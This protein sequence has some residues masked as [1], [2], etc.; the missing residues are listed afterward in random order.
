MKVS[1]LNI[2]K[3]SWGLYISTVTTW[4]AI[5]NE[6]SKGNELRNYFVFPW[7]A[8]CVL[9]AFVFEGLYA[10][11]KGMETGILNGIISAVSLLG[12][13]FLSNKI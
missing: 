9:V 1:K 13:Y 12:G 8:L 5:A 3:H 2:L 10:P 11:A 6:T 4:D 7:I